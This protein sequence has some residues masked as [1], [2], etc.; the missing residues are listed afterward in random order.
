MIAI[1]INEKTHLVQGTPADAAALRSLLLGT[2]ATR[3][4]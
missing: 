4:D 3:N 2:G 1:Q